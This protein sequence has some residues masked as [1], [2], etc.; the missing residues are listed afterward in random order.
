MSRFVECASVREVA[1]MFG[2]ASVEI[3]EVTRRMNVWAAE[4]SMILAANV[5]KEGGYK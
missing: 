3:K 2:I 4:S 1:K 5:L